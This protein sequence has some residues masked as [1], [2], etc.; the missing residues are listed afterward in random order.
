MLIVVIGIDVP[1]ILTL[2]PGLRKPVPRIMSPAKKLDKI[3]YIPRPIIKPEK[4]ALAS[5][6][7]PVTPKIPAT[8]N[9]TTM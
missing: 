6:D 9:P 7:S 5:I 4:V 2:L 3:G 8:T 1:A